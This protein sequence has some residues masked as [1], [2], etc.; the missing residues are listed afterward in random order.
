MWAELYS[1]ERHA[2][3]LT[4]VTLFGNRGSAD[5]TNMHRL[6]EGHAGLEQTMSPLTAVFSGR[7]FADRYREKAAFC[8][9]ARSRW[10]R[11]KPK[12]AQTAAARSWQEANTD[13]FPESSEGAWPSQTC[14]PAGLQL[15]ERIHFC[16]LMVYFVM[17]PDEINNRYDALLLKMIKIYSVS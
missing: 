6:I 10:C 11:H 17:A 2:E 14:D 4:S 13:P 7:R 16:Q 9:Q 3:V 1:P 15:H 8:R 5:N 12:K